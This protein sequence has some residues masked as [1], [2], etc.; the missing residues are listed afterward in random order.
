M[1]NLLILFFL[2][3]ITMSQKCDR[4]TGS[5]E[6]FANAVIGIE[7]TGCFGTCPIYKF[8]ING[9]GKAVYSGHRFVMV[10]GKKEKIF[11][12][13]QTM[14]LF[15]AF[16]EADFWDFEDVYTNEQ[17]ADLPT[18]YLT[19]SRGG[20]SKKIALRYGFP[21]KL[22]A[23]AK[24]TES[25]ANSEHWIRDENGNNTYNKDSYIKVKTTG[26]YGTCPIYEFQINGDGSASYV[27]ERFVAVKGERKKDFGFKETLAIFETFNSADFWS[28]EDEYSENITDL[29]TTFLTYSHGGNTK[30][31]RLYYGFP[32]KLEE[33]SGIIKRYAN[34][35]GWVKT[36]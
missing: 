36:Y 32:K 8:E 14:S 19:Y 20:K 21:D 34:S 10:N 9:S 30:T 16:E 6:N 15:K 26:C 24:L 33:L 35:E 13:K 18:T 11:D 12:K 27:G 17:I 5:D 7:K 4:K 22:D 29:P 31:I 23:L 3:L 28:F 1:K 25:F 2:A